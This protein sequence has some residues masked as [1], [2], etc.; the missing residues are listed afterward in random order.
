MMELL[1]PQ[2]SGNYVDVSKNR[3]GSFATL[4]C[5]NAEPGTEMIEKEGMF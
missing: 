4:H 3:L 2:R 1:F 5:L